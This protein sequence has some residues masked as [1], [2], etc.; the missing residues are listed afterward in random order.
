MNDKGK[1]KA[2]HKPTTALAKEKAR[3]GSLYPVRRETVTHKEPL[4]EVRGDSARIHEGENQCESSLQECSVLS[5]ETVTLCGVKLQPYQKRY[6]TLVLTTKRLN[7]F[8]GRR[9]VWSALVR[10]AHSILNSNEAH[11]KFGG[12]HPSVPSETRT[13]TRSGEG[14]CVNLRPAGNGGG[15]ASEGVQT[16]RS[17][18]RSHRSPARKIQI[19]NKNKQSNE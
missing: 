8:R 15:V 11:E 6:L 2:S 18:R 13:A 4:H 12:G 10:A 5:D 7:L 17:P 3:K 14:T 16:L 9:S 1:Q 19:K